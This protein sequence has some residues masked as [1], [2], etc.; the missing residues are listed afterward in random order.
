MKSHD[1][2]YYT[3]QLT[4]EC[5]SVVSQAHRKTQR[6]MENYPNEEKEKVVIELCDRL[7]IGNALEVA[8]HVYSVA[9]NNDTYRRHVGDGEDDIS[10]TVAEASQRVSESH[11]EAPSV[12]A[13]GESTF[14]NS[15]PERETST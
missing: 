3:F 4:I 9:I 14:M 11:S 10:M 15:W 7:D 6:T 1:K 8:Q 5:S 2:Q 12:A 13:S